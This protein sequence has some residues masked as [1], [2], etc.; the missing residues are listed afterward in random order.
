LR[1]DE[2][3]DRRVV[4]VVADAEV[5]FCEIEDR[6]AVIGGE[7]ADLDETGSGSEGRRVLILC[8]ERDSETNESGG[9]SHDINLF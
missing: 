3:A 2:E 1:R 5:V 9:A 8:E 4:F 7:D 6:L